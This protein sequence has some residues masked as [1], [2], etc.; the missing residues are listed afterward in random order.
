MA[1]GYYLQDW[2]QLANLEASLYFRLFRLMVPIIVKWRD[3]DE[4]DRRVGEDEEEREAKQKT[5]E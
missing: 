1:W 3:E 5:N 2:H 4:I